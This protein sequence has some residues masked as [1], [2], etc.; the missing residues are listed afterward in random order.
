MIPPTIRL[1]WRDDYCLE[2]Q[3]QRLAAIPAVAANLATTAP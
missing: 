2:A 1:Y 3:A